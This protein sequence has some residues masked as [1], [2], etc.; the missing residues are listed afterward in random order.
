MSEK[1]IRLNIYETKWQYIHLLNH[2]SQYHVCWEYDELDVGA[3][4]DEG[5]C[6]RV[7]LCP[8]TVNTLS[9]FSSASKKG[10]KSRSSVSLGSSN[11]DVTG[12]WRVN[13]RTDR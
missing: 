4:V 3:L 11:H 5:E 1:W 12:T 8:R 6:D 2:S 10:I 13:G 7:L 9:T